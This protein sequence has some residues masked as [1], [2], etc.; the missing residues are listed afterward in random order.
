MPTTL[1]NSDLQVM[2]LLEAQ[3]GARA[4][5]VVVLGEEIVFVVEKGD[6]G[7]AIGKN[8]QNILKLRRSL[9]HDVTV[10]ESAGDIR[11]FLSNVFKPAKLVEIRESNA[12]GRKVANVVVNAEDKGIAI[13]KGGSR[14]KVARVLSQRLFGFDDVKIV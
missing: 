6:L 7:K 2:N 1:S 8:G 4:K 11:S 3:T 13:G 14:V 9:G 12:P 10:V 5:D